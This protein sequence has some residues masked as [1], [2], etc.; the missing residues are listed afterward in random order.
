MLSSE[1]ARKI[2][3]TAEQ[4]FSADVVSQTVKRMAMDI[5]TLLS[6]QYPLVLSIMGGAVVFTGQL[7]PLL[8]FPLN[9]DY[10]HVSRYDNKTHG[11]KLNWTVLPREN[12]Q[13]RVVLV[14]DDILDEGITLAAI[15]ERVMNQGAAAFYSAVFA[16]KDI[17]RSKPIRA[18]FVG[19]V[20]PD[21]YVFGFGMDVRGAWR[22]L[23]AIY[24]V[25][26]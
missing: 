5:T 17:G 24:A 25:K 1:E 8:E 18:D 16:D 7:L 6:H 20:V 2:F 3:R 12:V 15:R 9:F 19:V 11:G 10:L 13:N 23:P 21:R 4:I 14:L 26:E 22:N